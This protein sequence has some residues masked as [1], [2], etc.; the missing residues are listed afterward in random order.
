MSTK[1][2]TILLAVILV[3]YGSITTIF[4]S[5]FYPVVTNEMAL[6]QLEDS[7]QS[8]TG[9]ASY[10]LAMKLWEGGWVIMVVIV[11]LSYRKEIGKLFA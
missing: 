9:W 10:N 5:V 2:K 8:Y 11:I 6:G 7:A 4:H 1:A 3:I